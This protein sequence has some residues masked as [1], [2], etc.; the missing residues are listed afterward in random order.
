MG[1]EILTRFFN[2]KIVKMEDKIKIKYMKIHTY[3]ELEQD[4][5]A[6]EVA[7]KMIDSGEIKEIPLQKIQ[8]YFCYMQGMRDAYMKL[9]PKIIA[10]AKKSER[11]YLE[12][13]YKLLTSCIDACYDYQQGFYELRYRNHKRDKKGNLVSCEAYFVRKSTTLKE[14]RYAKK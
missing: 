12:A 5:K 6:K 11:P 3:D 8:F 7:A 9:F 13:E 4:R 10:L 2:F 14:V 1:S